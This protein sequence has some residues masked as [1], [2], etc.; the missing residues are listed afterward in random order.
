MATSPTLETKP[1]MPRSASGLPEQ[2][3]Q[4]KFSGEYSAFAWAFTAVLG[5]ITI[6]LEPPTRNIL[7]L[8]LPV[9]VMGAYTWLSYPRG[10]MVVGWRAARIAQLADSVYFL[11]FLWTLWALIDSFVLKSST[12][13]D[14]AF[15]IFGYALITT[16]AG[17]ATRL[18]LLNFK[19]T[20]A[21]Q[22]EEAQATVEESLQKFSQVALS[23]SETI[24]VFRDH[25]V[26]LNTAVERL[27]GTVSSLERNFTDAHQQTTKNL[28]ETIAQVVEEIRA[29]LKSPVQEY[30]RALRAFT[31]NVNKESDS[32]KLAFEE[33]TSKIKSTISDASNTVAELLKKTGDKIAAD[34]VALTDMSASE[35]I[36]IVDTLQKFSKELSTIESPSAL[37]DSMDTSLNKLEGG[38][39]KLCTVLSPESQLARNIDSISGDIEASKQRITTA[40][41]ELLVRLGSVEV[42]AKVSI[43]ITSLTKV[44]DELRTSV[45]ALL[46]SA[47]DSRWQE[48][49]RAA[50]DSFLQLAQSINKL[51][52]AMDTENTSTHRPWWRWS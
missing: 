18:Y 38:V 2:K 8:F 14:A 45:D 1:A 15:R 27:S 9:F 25:T 21:D 46:A 44:I 19:Y 31:A 12:S 51:R 47:V 17:M 26:A 40:F 23:T 50:S 10:V 48:A 28:K 11:G 39:E 30:G 49:P 33:S 5:A 36:R 7:R 35:F 24:N 37:F 20:S 16:A 52:A 4:A 41:S 3:W 42:P 34:N 29:T 13:T 6:S 43:D 32:F 22:A